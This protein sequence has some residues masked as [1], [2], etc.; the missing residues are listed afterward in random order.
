MG[1]ERKN[2]TGKTAMIVTIIPAVEEVFAIVNIPGEIQ[3]PGGRTTRLEY[4]H[5]LVLH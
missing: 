2:G 5:L 1:I 3:E 4:K